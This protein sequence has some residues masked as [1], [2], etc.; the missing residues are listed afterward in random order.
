MTVNIS[1]SVE[2]VCKWVRHI[3]M[4]VLVIDHGTEIITWGEIF[5]LNLTQHQSFQLND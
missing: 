4:M 5:F 3:G 1:Y 2:N